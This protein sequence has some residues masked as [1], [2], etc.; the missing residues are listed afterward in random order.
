MEVTRNRN[1]E[2]RNRTDLITALAFIDSTG[3]IKKIQ[4]HGESEHA[5]TVSRDIPDGHEIIGLTYSNNKTMMTIQNLAFL[6]WKKSIESTA[7][8]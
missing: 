2:H 4:G 5:D 3:S 1:G 6:L 7:V 8:E